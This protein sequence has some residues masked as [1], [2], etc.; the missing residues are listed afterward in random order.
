MLRKNVS[1][2]TRLQSWALAPLRSRGRPVSWTNPRLR[3]GNHLYLWLQAHAQKS[4]GKDLLI[5]S[6]PSMELG[7]EIFPAAKNL[8]IDEA[9]V[10][11]SDQRIMEPAEVFQRFGIDFT[12]E[13]LRTFVQEIIL[14]APLFAQTTERPTPDDTLVVNVRRGDYYSVPA[15]RD[16]YSFNISDYIKAALETR[17]PAVSSIKKVLVISDG[18]GWCRENLGWLVDY[19]PVEW[20]APAGSSPGEH[21]YK[22]STAK[23][24]ILPNSTFSYWGGYISNTIHGDNHAFTIAPRFHARGLH[25]GVAWQ[26]DPKW[27]IVEDIP[28]HWDRA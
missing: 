6:T 1:A 18:I 13:E 26:L 16:M 4:R 28:D 21:F 22:L 8:C 27:S 3:M 23:N 17:L 9:N 12:P 25:S 15:F 24:L 2:R 7:L 10:R 20:V 11:F 14:S 19:G 5:R